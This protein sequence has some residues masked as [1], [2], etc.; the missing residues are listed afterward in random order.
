MKTFT[1][2]IPIE[3]EEYKGSG[4]FAP[5]IHA[6]EILH[7][8]FQDAQIQCR[9][10]A[11]KFLAKEDEKMAELLNNRADYWERLFLQVTTE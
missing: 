3:A 1:F 9:I 11:M 7:Q 2:K 8:L 6:R 5:E 10:L 4:D